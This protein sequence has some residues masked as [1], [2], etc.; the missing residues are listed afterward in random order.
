MKAIPALAAALLAC[1]LTF[2][3]FAA[4]PEKSA[5][6]QGDAPPRLFVKDNKIVVP[7]TAMM[8]AAQKCQWD[9]WTEAKAC[10][11]KG[12]DSSDCNIVYQSCVAY[13]E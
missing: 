9:C 10:A 11:E 12:G 2:G 6:S 4:E 5:D 1:G 13:C 7:D 8:D 3:A